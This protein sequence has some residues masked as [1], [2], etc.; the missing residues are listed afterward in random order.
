MLHYRTKC[1]C[2]ITWSSSSSHELKMNYYYMCDICT[3]QLRSKCHF[4]Q[5]ITEMFC[6][7]ICSMQLYRCVASYGARAPST[8][9]NFIFSSLWNKSDSQLSKYCVVCEISR[10][11][12]QQLTALSTSIALVTKLLVIEQSAV[13]SFAPPHNKCWR[14]H[15]SYISCFIIQCC[16]ILKCDWKRCDEVWI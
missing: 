11:R 4:I 12:C 14:R 16:E 2:L 6:P 5:Q 9:N 8:S 13:S 1:F 3:E 15:G 10:C 7:V